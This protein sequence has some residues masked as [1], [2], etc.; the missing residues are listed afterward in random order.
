MELWNACLLSFHKHFLPKITFKIR[1]TEDWHVPVSDQR[2]QQSS[3]AAR[4]W[5][6]HW[7]ARQSNKLHRSRRLDR[8]VSMVSLLSDLRFRDENS[9]A[10]LHKSGSRIWRTRLRRSRPRRY[11]V[12]RCAALSWPCQCHP[13]TS[14]R[15]MVNL[16]TLARVFATVQWRWDLITASIT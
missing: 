6:L 16:G 9:P 4:W 15:T 11:H 1:S 8:L 13:A 7:C 5:E 2:M 12:H 3:A 10:K 14:E